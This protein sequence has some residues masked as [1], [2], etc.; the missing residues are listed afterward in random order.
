MR[1]WQRCFLATAILLVTPGCCSLAQ[2]F[3]GP[4]QSP[5]IP[6]SYGTPEDAL[7]TFLE[8]MR[9][10]DSRQLYKSLSEDFKRRE[11]LPGALE[12]ELAWRQLRASYSYL[13]LL[14]NAEVGNSAPRGSRYHSFDLSI[15]GEVY[16]VSLRRQDFIRVVYVVP[17]LEEPL[18]AGR[19]VDS[20]EGFLRI[21]PPDLAG[22][23]IVVT[24]PEM[25]IEE[26]SHEDL[27]RAEIGRSWKLD[28][29]QVLD[30][31]A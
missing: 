3:C 30:P 16:R 7:A 8:A 26:L 23:D 12:F 9:R 19:Y 18:E 14:S 2:F 4:D 6:K 20:L 5:W 17:E 10:D 31:D 13:H 15:G 25:E 21:D 22:L 24:L 1:R 11:G 28:A 29:F 27:L